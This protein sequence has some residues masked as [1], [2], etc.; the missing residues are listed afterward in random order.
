MLITSTYLR[1]NLV[2]IPFDLKPQNMV[3][4]F[5]RRCSMKFLHN[6]SFD[7]GKNFFCKLV[8]NS[9]LH[10]VTRSVFLIE[11]QVEENKP[12]PT[13]AWPV[14]WPPLAY[15]C[16]T[17]PPDCGH[18]CWPPPTLLSRPQLPHLPLDT[19]PRATRRRHPFRAPSAA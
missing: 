7:F 11:P 16:P 5:D 1:E 12:M 9:I 2:S 17:A 3:L 14:A 13:S 10:P 6:Q 18:R 15:Q 8:G 4:L 19:L